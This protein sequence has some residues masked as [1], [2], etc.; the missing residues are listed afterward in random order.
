MAIE[1]IIYRA[2]TCNMGDTT[3]QDGDNYR[4]WAKSELEKKYTKA[5]VEVR[6]EDDQSEIRIALGND[7][8]EM[9]AEWDEANVFMCELWD[10]CPWYGEF[11][12]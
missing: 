12:E 10:R 5:L 1:K 3:E 4:A 8:A 2:A 11:F 7:Y 6:N 9:D